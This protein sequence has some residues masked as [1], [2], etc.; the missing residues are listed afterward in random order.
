MTATWVA[1]NTASVFA[2]TYRSSSSAVNSAINTFINSTSTNGSTVITN[3][4]G[5]NFYYQFIIQP[6][7]GINATG[8]SGD[9][10]STGVKRNTVSGG[11]TTY[12]F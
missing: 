4:G 1:T 5:L 12:T 9:G 7:S 3:T 2:S 10:R 6:W 8:E 11:P